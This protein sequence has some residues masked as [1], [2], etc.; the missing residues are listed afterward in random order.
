[1]SNTALSAA[2]AIEEALADAEPIWVTLPPVEV[3]ISAAF[4]RALDQFD[5]GSSSGGVAANGWLQQNAVTDYRLSRTTLYIADGAIAG[6]YSLC[7]SSVEVSQRD[8]KRHLEL[9]TPLGTLPASLV[10]WLAKDYRA[11]IDGSLLMK[12]AFATARR[13][14][15]TQAAIVLALDPF[16]ADTAELWKAHYGFRKASGCSGRL[17]TPLFA[18]D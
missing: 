1:M 3:E 9:H 10:T 7:S 16:D 6:F 11:D 18:I 2:E 17:W 14:A 13:T 4:R 8:R 5:A 12:H 15:L